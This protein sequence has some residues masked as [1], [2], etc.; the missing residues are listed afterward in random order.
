MFSN[1][2]TPQIILLTIS[3]VAVLVILLVLVARLIRSEIR[4]SKK[5]TAEFGPDVN[6]PPDKKP[7]TT[8]V[9]KTKYPPKQPMKASFETDYRP[10]ETSVINETKLIIPQKFAALR[11]LSALIKAIAILVAIL[12]Y[13][14]SGIAISGSFNSIGSTLIIKGSAV[15]SGLIGIV[16][17]TIIGILIY[18]YGDFIQCVIDIEHNTRQTALNSRWDNKQT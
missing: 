10:L 1:L 4:D 15:A 8:S 9:P 5:D 7:V 6:F 14:L 18:A 17:S 12:G 2:E 16:F 11:M 3:G 13:V